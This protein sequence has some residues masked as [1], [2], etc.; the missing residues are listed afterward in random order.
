MRLG[1]SRWLVRGEHPRVRSWTSPIRR[2][3]RTKTYPPADRENAPSST[4]RQKWKCAL[5]RR[6]AAAVT[7]AGSR[8]LSGSCAIFTIQGAYNVYSA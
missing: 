1:E 7:V 4:A 2:G 6:Q 5:R 3:A 8:A